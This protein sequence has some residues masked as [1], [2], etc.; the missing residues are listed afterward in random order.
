MLLYVFALHL[1]NCTFIAIGLFPPDVSW[2]TNLSDI[3][4]LIS[5][6]GIQSQLSLN[7]EDESTLYLTSLYFITTTITT[8]GYGDIYGVSMLERVFIILLQFLGILLFTTVK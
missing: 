3:N 1:L 2:I 6:K 7:M 4:D 8:V 5:N